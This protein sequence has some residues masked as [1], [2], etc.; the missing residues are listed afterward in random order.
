MNKYKVE[1]IETT[2]YV[3]DVKAKNEREATE[4]ARMKFQELSK[5]GI[6]HHQETESDTQ[7]AT[8]YDVTGT[9]DPFNP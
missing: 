7:V 8:V 9:D 1:F 3:I 6:L 2:L 5:Q 4:K